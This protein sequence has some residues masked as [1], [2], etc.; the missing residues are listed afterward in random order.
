MLTIVRVLCLQLCGE[1]Y[2]W[3]WRSAL[4]PAS[5]STYMF[6]YCVYY[7]QV[8]LSIDDFTST[9]LY[10]AYVELCWTGT[11]CEVL[12]RGAECSCGFVCVCCGT[13]QIYGTGIACIRTGRGCYRPH[14]D[15]L[16]LAN[17][18]QLSEGR[19]ILCRDSGETHTVQTWRAARRKLDHTELSF[20]TAFKTECIGYVIFT[21]LSTPLHDRTTSGQLSQAPQTRLSTH[22]SGASGHVTL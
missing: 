14:R 10:F 21:L 20:A 22:Q 16:L 9:L 8:W 7:F 1:N 6:L 12:I 11:V 5:S 13:F 19:L 17:Y 3:W 2:H 18:L 15:L 4:I